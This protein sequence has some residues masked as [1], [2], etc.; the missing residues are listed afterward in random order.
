MVC[1]DLRRIAESDLMQRINIHITPSI[2]LLSRV[3]SQLRVNI[4][5]SAAL[6][7]MREFEQ[8]V[9][10]FYAEAIVDRLSDVSWMV[11]DD[12]MYALR[13]LDIAELTK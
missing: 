3:Y 12:A 4:M 13:N 1:N 2:T 9:I 7:V 8:D 10:A 6:N 5:R 11:K